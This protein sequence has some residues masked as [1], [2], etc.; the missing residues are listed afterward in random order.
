MDKTYCVLSATDVDSVALLA[1]RPCL[2][3]KINAGPLGA[4]SQRGDGQSELTV[5]G[6]NHRS[7]GKCLWRNG[8]EQQGAQPRI[9]NRTI[10]CQ[11]IRS[12]EYTSE[13]QSR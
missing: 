5:F 7:I 11:R 10:G 8:Y 2:H 1:I 13:L 4:A 3:V 9:Q 12:E 6:N